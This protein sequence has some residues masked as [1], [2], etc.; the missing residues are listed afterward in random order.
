MT[1]RNE[2]NSIQE[3]LIDIT[4]ALIKEYP[5]NKNEISA[6]YAA[7][8][9]VDSPES[10]DSLEAR[11]RMTI[12]GYLIGGLISISGRGTPS[13]IIMSREGYESNNIK[14]DYQTLCNFTI[15]TPSVP[16]VNSEIKE[17]FL[18]CNTVFDD[19]ISWGIIGENGGVGDNFN[20]FCKQVRDECQIKKFNLNGI[21]PVSNEE[22]LRRFDEFLKTRNK[23]YSEYS[24]IVFERMEPIMKEVSSMEGGYP[25]ALFPFHQNDSEISTRIY[26]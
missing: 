9:L 5:L 10:F 1:S 21:T 11:K 19:N 24:Q 8:K 13:N 16:K 3:R 17:G 14:Y 12:A 20:E 18:C 22:L 15:L 25:I 6:F 7:R 2:M 26:T 4:K 23:K